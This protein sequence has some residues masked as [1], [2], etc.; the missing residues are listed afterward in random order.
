V[1]ARTR[2]GE[3]PD[4]SEAPVLDAALHAL[5]RGWSVVP[6]HS[7]AAGRCSCGATACPSL[8]K[9]P[10]VP[11]ERFSLRR[12]DPDQV[13]R[14]WARWPTA[15]LG[16]VTGVLSGLVVVDV[17]PRAGG[18]DAL[19]DLEARHGAF[20]DTVECLSG[21]GGM[22][23][24]FRHPGPHVRSGPV[25]AGIDVKADGGVVVAPPS[26][27]RS[28]VRYVWEFGASPDEH[29]LAD[30]PAWLAD[31]VLR[32]GEPVGTGRVFAPRTSEERHEF[33]RLWDGLGV[34]IE[35]GDRYYLCPF[36]D[37]HHP[38]LHI[39][40]DGCR[41][42]C[43]GCARGGG[44]GRLRRLADRSR[45]P[46][47]PASGRATSELRPELHGAHARTVPVTW[48][49]WPA[50]QPGGAQPVVG[51]TH[52]ADA[53]ERIGGGRTWVGTRTDW[54]TARLHREHANPD[55]PD[56]VRVDIGGAT[57]GYLPRRDA[58]R[59]HAVLAELTHEHTP[60]TARARLT[61]GWERGPY[62]RGSIGV[63]LDIDPRVARRRTDAPFLPAELAI[64]VHTGTQHH[65]AV[66]GLLDGATSV[67][68]VATLYVARDREQEVL[69]VRIGGCEMGELGEAMG[70]RYLPLVERVLTAG[71]PATCAATIARGTRAHRVRV[72][73]PR[74]AAPG[75]SGAPRRHHDP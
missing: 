10:R 61:G 16:V 33:A 35:A 32:H 7:V 11:W 72:R 46:P 4:T 28:G 38:S 66:A 60:A 31:R 69:R 44:P 43:F 5:R 3:D 57:V 17:D 36:H 67:D 59:F 39:D 40:A 45:R 9:H 19:A 21:G 15:N 70:T 6:M 68:V 64:A 75:A 52:Y 23:L 62:G 12:P 56:A 74:L 18:D 14:W 26:V 49:Q 8:G 29:E 73:L 50:L 51:E 54:V 25:A 13:H 41:W 63:V 71:Y 34:R 30:L 53:L 2:V 22:H 37:D 1:S 20:P 27:H 48:L 24:Y 58:R 42:Y 47:G 55:D 65:R